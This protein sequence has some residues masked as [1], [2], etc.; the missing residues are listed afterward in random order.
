VRSMGYTIERVNARFR[1]LYP[2]D[3]AVKNMT[4]RQA[5]TT[6]RE[7]NQELY[8]SS[9]VAARAQTTL[10]GIED[11]NAAAR[12]ILSQSEGNDSQVAQLQSALQMLALM[13][14]NLVNINRLISSS[15]RISSNQAVSAVTMR[16]I[17]NERAAQ[18][19]NDYVKSEAIPEVDSRLLHPW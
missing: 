13:H 15:G 18:M 6:A 5:E 12:N 19:A 1:Q 14:D 9:L 3:R 2:D 11:N 10:R 4:P 17:E 7:M 16:R 8:E